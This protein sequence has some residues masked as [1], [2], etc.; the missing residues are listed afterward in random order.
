MA[1]SSWRRGAALAIRGQSFNIYDRSR[2]QWHQTWV[3]STGG[4]HEYWGNLKDG[5]MVYE[6]V[7]PPTPGQ[8]GPQ[9]TRMT[10]FNLGPGQGAA[11]RRAHERRRK[12]VADGLRLHLYEKVIASAIE[13]A[14]R[15]MSFS[16]VRQFEIEMRIA[17]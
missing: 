12:N 4:L 13:T 6:R 10:F 15:S 1:A 2:A 9:Q 3:D 7:V 5:N 8:K 16:V 17:G 11:I 14:D